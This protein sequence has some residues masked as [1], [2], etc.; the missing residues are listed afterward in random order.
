MI[1]GKWRFRSCRATTAVTSLI[2]SGR[3]KQ[4]TWRPSIWQTPIGAWVIMPISILLFA[5]IFAA[6]FSPVISWALGDGTPGIFVAR[7]VDCHHGC[8]WV[9]EFLSSDRRAV[10]ENVQL[11]NS[12][13]LPRLKAGATVSVVDVDSPLFGNT[14]YPGHATLSDILWKSIWPAELLALLLLLVFARWIWTVP[15]R[16]W[17]FRKDLASDPPAFSGKTRVIPPPWSRRWP[18]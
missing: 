13:S 5:A 12:G 18:R 17:R 3:S 15:I 1:G 16:Y 9:G 2:R 7:F 11:V 4:G 8:A 14:A 10:A 6:F